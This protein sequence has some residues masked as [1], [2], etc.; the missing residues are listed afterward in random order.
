[1]A[2]DPNI[3][4]AYGQAVKNN[5]MMAADGITTQAQTEFEEIAQQSRR[6]GL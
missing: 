4:V 5:M 3:K 2:E 6:P 1:M